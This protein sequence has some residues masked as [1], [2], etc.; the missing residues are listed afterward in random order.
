MDEVQVKHLETR[1]QNWAAW[2]R[3]GSSVQGTCASAERRYVPPRDDDET[4]AR[5]LG[6]EPIW[7]GDA[8]LVDAAVARL[9][10]A[11]LKQMI[12]LQYLDRYDIASMAGFY[13]TTVMMLRARR[14]TAFSA[15]QDILDSMADHIVKSK[16]ASRM[17]Q[18]DRRSNMYEEDD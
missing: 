5:L 1:L 2:S 18:P 16:R 3:S 13:R 10:E 7:F 11:D 9:R 14:L 17:L 15:L 12:T 8:E 4:R 6:R